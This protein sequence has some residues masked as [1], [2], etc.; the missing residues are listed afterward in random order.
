MFKS[1][2]SIVIGFLLIGTTSSFAQPASYQPPT[3]TNKKNTSAKLLPVISADDYRKTIKAAAEENKHELAQEVSQTLS[4]VP[5]IAPPPAPTSQNSNPTQAPSPS[6]GQSQPVGEFTPP[7]SAAPPASTEGS[8]IPGAPP[9]SSYSNTQTTAP[10]YSN[11]P[12]ATAPTYP[13]QG[14]SQ[15]YTGFQAPPAPTG[16]APVQQ[17]PKSG[18][19]NIKY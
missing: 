17:Q 9:P 10:T 3:A 4:K 18:G 12:S 14:G 16:A 11:A 7:I 13:Q 5:R 6:P 8:V 2:S 1:I 19:W 15:T